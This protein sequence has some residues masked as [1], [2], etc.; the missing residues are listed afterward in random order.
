[1]FYCAL[2]PD[3]WFFLCPVGFAPAHTGG[4]PQRSRGHELCV[5]CVFSWERAYCVQT[6]GMAA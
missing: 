1:M 2:Q 3:C 5:A 4:S 6:D